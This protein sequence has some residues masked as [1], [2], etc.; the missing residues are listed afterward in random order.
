MLPGTIERM[1]VD[2][3]RGQYRIRKWPKKRGTPTDPIQLQRIE[4]FANANRLAKFIAG[5]WWVK[6]HKLTRGTGLYPRD[7]LVRSMTAGFADIVTHDGHL[8]TQKQWLLEEAVFQGARIEKN[9]GQGYTASAAAVVTWQVPVIQTWPL[10]SAG[11]PNRL[12][13]GTNI[14]IVR[15]QAAL[16]L[17]TVVAGYVQVSIRK[18]GSTLI[19]SSN[20]TSGAAPAQQCNTGPIYVANGDYFEVLVQGANNNTVE[21]IDRTF[22]ACE[23]LNTTP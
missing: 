12:T 22:F 5:P 17:S 11:S 6:A 3:F 15:L 9:A 2:T 14:N 7:L 21:A 16:R 18:N 13:I 8:I 23:I 4:R 19:A 10:W 20:A 1:V